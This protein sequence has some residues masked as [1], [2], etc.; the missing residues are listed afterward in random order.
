MTASKNL[1]KREGPRR[2]FACLIHSLLDLVED[3]EG[4]L[5][6]SL[7]D[8]PALLQEVSLDVGPSDEPTLIKVDPDEL[9]LQTQRQT[10]R[11][12]SEHLE[13]CN[14]TVSVDL[15]R[16]KFSNRC[17]PVHSVIYTSSV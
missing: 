1:K 14:F 17:V 6:G 7:A 12:S 11:M 5:L 13:R 9:A 16:A 8:R 2:T 3:V 15:T 4:P 10:D